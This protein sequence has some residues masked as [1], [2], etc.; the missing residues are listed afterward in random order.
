MESRVNLPLDG[1]SISR[2]HDAGEA[3]ALEDHL[4]GSERIEGEGLGMVGT[5]SWD[6][7]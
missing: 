3:L 1:L 2:P 7:P 6:P 5:R 4:L